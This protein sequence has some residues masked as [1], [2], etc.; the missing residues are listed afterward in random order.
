MEGDL[1]GKYLIAMPGMGD[2]R[3]LEA[4]IYMCSHSDGGAMG[5]IVNKPV[6]DLDFGELAEQLE[7][8][9]DEPFP[10]VPVHYGGPVENG[11]GFVLHSR[12][13]DLNTATLKVTDT[14]GM[15]GTLE[16]VEDIAQ[17]FGPDQALFALGYAGWSPGQLEGEIRSNGWLVLTGEDDFIFTKDPSTSW[18]KAFDQLGVDRRFLS[19]EAGRA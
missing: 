19:G 16:V 9:S 7:I 15:T 3:F 6:P 5:L 2:P 13:Y 17:G 1:T 11:R 4:V 8:D 18:G 14:I 10:K 12:D